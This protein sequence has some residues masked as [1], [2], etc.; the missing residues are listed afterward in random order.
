MKEYRI[1]SYDGASWLVFSV[2]PD[3]KA[4]ARIVTPTPALSLEQKADIRR[5]WCGTGEEL[6]RALNPRPVPDL[7]VHFE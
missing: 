6:D 2:A 3:G 7:P 4:S 1:R 5:D